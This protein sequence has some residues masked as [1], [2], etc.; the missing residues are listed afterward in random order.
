MRLRRIPSLRKTHTLNTWD[1]TC[2]V[3]E[4]HVLYAA[5]KLRPYQWHSRVSN[6]TIHAVSH[7]DP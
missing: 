6:D 7:T 3:H 2:Y 4:S 5:Q 1:S